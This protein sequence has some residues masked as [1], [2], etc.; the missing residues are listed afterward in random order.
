M[1]API[2]EQCLPIFGVQAAPCESYSFAGLNFGETDAQGI[3]ANWKLGNMVITFIFG[4]LNVPYTLKHLR[5]PESEA[6]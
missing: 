2:A 6:A 4:A 1:Y 5:Q 3:W